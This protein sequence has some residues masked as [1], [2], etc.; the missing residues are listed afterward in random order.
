[1]AWEGLR[2]PEK[3]IDQPLS[4]TRANP[5]RRHQNQGQDSSERM[6]SEGVAYG[7]PDGEEDPTPDDLVRGR[8][9]VAQFVG[10]ASSPGAGSG[11]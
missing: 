2:G 4:L 5:I 3:G 9:G 11:W 10:S 1:M 7:G 8:D 6:T